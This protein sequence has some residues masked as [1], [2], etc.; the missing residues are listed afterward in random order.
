[1]LDIAGTE[2]SLAHLVYGPEAF[3]SAPLLDPK[4]LPPNPL[5]DRLDLRSA[6]RQDLAAAP[7]EP[8]RRCRRTN[9]RRGSR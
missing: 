7:P 1:M 5:P 4:P 8:T 6:F 2:T 3:R 9:D